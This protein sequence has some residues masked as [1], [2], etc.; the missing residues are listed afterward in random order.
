MYS[1]RPAQI[2]DSAAIAHIN[3]VTWFSAYR[4][5]FD[6]GFLRNRSESARTESQRNWFATKTESDYAYVAENPLG[7]V[8]GY[9][10]GGKE[11][12]N[13]PE[14]LGE[15][16]A[17]YILPDYHCQG[18]G[19]KLMHHASAHLFQ[20]GL[21]PYL[22]WVLEQN[23]A[24]GFYERLGGVYLAQKEIRVAEQSLTEI[25]YKF[26]NIVDNAS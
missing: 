16:G 10:V 20:F 17:I 6:E 22:V 9:V 3:I 14:V 15:I 23:L 2:E 24:R 21:F 26:L 4:A 13:F 5:I 1:V 8:V 11:R 19:R 18:I 12:S 7:E 25:A